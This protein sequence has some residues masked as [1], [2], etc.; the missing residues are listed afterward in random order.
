MPRYIKFLEPFLEDN[1]FKAAG[2]A[3]NPYD[4]FR[5]D[6]SNEEDF[7]LSNLIKTI[8]LPVDDKSEESYTLTYN[9]R[10]DHPIS[11]RIKRSQEWGGDPFTFNQFFTKVLQR[12]FEKRRDALEMDG[13]GSYKFGLLVNEYILLVVRISHSPREI[14][15]STMKELK[16]SDIDLLSSQIYDGRWGKIIKV[17]PKLYGIEKTGGKKSNV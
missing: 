6:F 4:I 8:K 14:Q 5:K 2:L 16:I 11:N 12:L 3:Q 9:T 15:L 17:F 10:P 1:L 13:L 7:Y